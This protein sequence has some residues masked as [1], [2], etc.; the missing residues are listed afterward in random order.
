ME[1]L[2]VELGT[3]IRDRGINPHEAAPEHVTHLIVKKRR[4]V[5]MH[6]VVG[7]VEV[8]EFGI[9]YSPLAD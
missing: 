7:T 9:H 8:T 6:P 4:Y 2:R 1:K 3:C 5:I